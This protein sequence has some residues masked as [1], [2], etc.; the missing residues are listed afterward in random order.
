MFTWGNGM[1]GVLGQNHTD[2]N[3]LIPTLVDSLEDWTFVKVST[4][5]GHMVGLTCCGKL[6]SWGLDDNG[7]L[8]HV[9]EEKEKN[10]K[11]YKPPSLKGGKAPDRV[12]GELENQKVVDFSCGSRFTAAITEDGSLYTWGMGRDY[13]LGHNDRN[14]V[15]APKKVEA[16]GDTKFKQVSCGRNFI[17]A[18][19]VNGFVHAWGN[20]DVG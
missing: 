18:L 10:S 5:S 13:V 15:T 8:G 11:R 4:G 7:Q 3:Q 17:I 20:N 19:D 6:V 14:K 9:K 16:L 1:D 2:S 12:G